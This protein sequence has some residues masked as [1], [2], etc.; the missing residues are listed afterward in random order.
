MLHLQ[1]PSQ[2]LLQPPTNAAINS[3]SLAIISHDDQTGEKQSVVRSNFCADG[4]LVMCFCC[5]SEWEM[6][7]Q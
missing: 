1:R 2:E 6:D 3:S 5:C 7:R 4:A